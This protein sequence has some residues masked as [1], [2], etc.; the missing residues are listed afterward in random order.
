[1]ENSL[2]KLLIGISSATMLVLAAMPTSA[3]MLS[4]QPT[5]QTAVPTDNISLNL[6]ISGLSAG[7]PNSL[8][9]FDIDIGFDSN[10]LS[11]QGYSIGTS[12]G[13]IN[14]F[15]AGDFSSGDLGGGIVNLAEISFLETDA[16]SCVFCIGPYLDDIQLDSFT[17]ATLEFKVD[18]LAVGSSTTVFF[19]T[20][21]ALGDGF[22]NPLAIDNLTNAIIQNPATSVPEPTTLALLALGLIGIAGRRRLM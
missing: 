8:G 19:A 18:T 15:E 7:G 16:T 17:L 10:A 6:V 13:D 4:L 21:F 11:F 2:R 14:L 12:L 20:V 1:M 9:D 22:G 5:V 3:V